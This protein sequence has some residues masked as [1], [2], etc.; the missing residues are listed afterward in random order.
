MLLQINDVAPESTKVLARELRE[1]TP[2]CGELRMQ[3]HATLETDHPRHV[4]KGIHEVR[5]GVLSKR[6]GVR[7]I[8]RRR[9]PHYIA[10]RQ[11]AIP[12]PSAT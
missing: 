11:T 5:P 12:K 6:S 10:V 7:V 1:A 3:E 9:A 2:G 4:R 8:R